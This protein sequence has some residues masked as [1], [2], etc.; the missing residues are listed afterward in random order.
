MSRSSSRRGWPET[1]TRWVR[2][3]M[4]STPCTTRPLTSADVALTGHAAFERQ[5]GESIVAQFLRISSEPVPDLHQLDIPEALSHAVGRAMARDP[6]ERP[7]SAGEFGAELGEIAAQTGLGAD[8]M[9]L[10][11][12]AE[13]DWLLAGT[14]PRMF[15]WKRFM[16]ALTSS[17]FQCVCAFGFG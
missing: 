2:S 17:M 9:A 14:G 8:E 3:V 1:C 6:A 5:S 7:A 15:H 11:L 10:R 12:D 13:G 4:I 16:P